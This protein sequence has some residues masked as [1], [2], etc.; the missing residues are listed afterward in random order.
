MCNLALEKAIKG[1]Y[2]EVLNQFP[3][4]THNLSYLIEKSGIKTPENIAKFLI[5]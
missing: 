3:P 2:H 5:K 4:K 1:Y